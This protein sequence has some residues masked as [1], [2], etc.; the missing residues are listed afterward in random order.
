MQ[1]RPELAEDFARLMT[2]QD[3]ELVAVQQEMR[4]L[5]HDQHRA[6]LL[7]SIRRFFR[8]DLA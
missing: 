4:S 7:Q 8:L 6:R 2:D 5:D 3:K 1:A